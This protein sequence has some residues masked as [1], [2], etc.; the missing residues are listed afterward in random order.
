VFASSNYFHPNVVTVVDEA[1][2]YRLAWAMSILLCQVPSLAHKVQ[3]TLITFP[4]TNTP[5][6]FSE[7][8]V[9]CSKIF[10]SS[11]LK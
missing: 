1:R 2:N 11:S 10:F 9:F 6:Y 3:D 8:D 7:K 5:A 4:G